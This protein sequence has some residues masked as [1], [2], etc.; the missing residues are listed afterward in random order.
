MAPVSVGAATAAPLSGRCDRFRNLRIRVG[1]HEAPVATAARIHTSPRLSFGPEVVL[2][3]Y[4][5]DR[6]LVMLTGNV[7]LDF[8]RPGAPRSTTGFLVFGAG[9]FHDRYS[10]RRS[11]IRNFGAFTAG[12]GFRVP[13]RSPLSVGGEAR[14]ANGHIRLGVT[15]KVL[16]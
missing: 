16:P 5:N 8:V 3:N 7:T 1:R 4:G 9:L 2:I 6:T 12:A 15:V 13:I 10:S 14:I 11:P